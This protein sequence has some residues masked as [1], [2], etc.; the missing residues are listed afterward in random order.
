MLIKFLVQEG[1]TALIRSLEFYNVDYDLFALRPPEDIVSKSLMYDA[2]VL[3]YGIGIRVIGK[4]YID[5]CSA[6]INNMREKDKIYSVSPQYCAAHESKLFCNA[7]I[8]EGIEDSH[9]A[10]NS[11]VSL[12][13]VQAYK[14]FEDAN[15]EDSVPDS[16]LLH[17]AKSVCY[18]PD[19]ITLEVVEVGA[20]VNYNARALCRGIVLDYTDI[21]YVDHPDVA[22]CMPF[23]YLKSF[24]RSKDEEYREVVAL[25][26]FTQDF[27]VGMRDYKEYLVPTQEEKPNAN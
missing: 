23:D 22:F 24:V 15:G 17:L 12:I 14:K 20:L 13:D 9:L 2:L 18:K 4:N 26:K 3:V 1:N 19:R 10:A 7:Y 27:F 5:T 6:L 8:W 11:N 25:D 21:I 16:S